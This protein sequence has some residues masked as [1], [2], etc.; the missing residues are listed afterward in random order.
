MAINPVYEPDIPLSA[1]IAAWFADLTVVLVL[2][3]PPV[4]TR[5]GISISGLFFA[6]PCFL[7]ES[8]LSRALLMCCMAF[9]FAIATALLLAPTTAGFRR[10]LAYFFAWMGARTIERNKR[11]FDVASLLRLIAAALVFAMGLA[12]LKA[13]SAAGIWLL[14]HWFAGA[15]M[16]LAFAEMATASH[17]WLTAMMGLNA[18]SLMRSPFLSKSVT[19]FWT[20]RWNVAASELGFRPLCFTPLARHGVVLALFAAFTASAVGHVLLAFVAMGRWGVSISCGAFF[21]VQP[22]LIIVERRIKVKRWPATAARAWTLAALGVTS[23]LFVEPVIQLIT[24]S[25][26][27]TDN[28]LPPTIA[29]LSF[30]LLVNLFF[31]AGQLAFC[32]ERPPPHRV[33]G[34]TDHVVNCS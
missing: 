15:V 32:V 8:P 3:A 17:D 16:I 29:A 5:L 11:G 19:E 25:L 33:V 6:V 12:S 1:G 34:A 31:S 27:V 2:S 18:P 30:A 7:R 4:T 20:K 23:P 21:I 24:P 28:P 13:L 10:R 14:L 26:G 22:L 9:P